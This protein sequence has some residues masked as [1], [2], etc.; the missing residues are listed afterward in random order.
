MAQE[1]VCAVCCQFG[2]AILS[3][4]GHILHERCFRNLPNR[5]KC[6]KCQCVLSDSFKIEKIYINI[7]YSDLND[8][9][10][11]KLWK[12][13]EGLCVHAFEKVSCDSE[14]LRQL[15]E[16]GWDVNDPECGGPNLFY[17]TCEKDDLSKMNLLIEHGIDLEKYGTNGLD[18]ACS[19]CSRNTFERLGNLGIKQ[20]PNLIF[21]LISR[22]YVNALKLAIENG[23]DVNAFNSRGQRPIHAAAQIESL[24]IIE[25]LVK[26]GADFNAVNKEGESIVHSVAKHTD[27]GKLLKYLQEC[28]FNLNAKD[29]YLMTPLMLAVQNRRQRNLEHLLKVVVDNLE[30]VDKYGRTVLHHCALYGSLPALRTL[31]IAGANVNAKDNE[32]R[33]PLHRV[34]ICQGRYKNDKVEYLLDH[35]ADISVRDS[36]GNLP[37][38]YLRKSLCDEL[39]KRFESIV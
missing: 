22:R 6:P 24:E 2:T 29:K 12:S 13:F 17:K 15:E 7:Q 30:D 4:C 33:T 26:N 38:Y 11:R 39:K 32:G 18:F 36:R 16:F 14:T 21:N 23:A 34:S 25:L 19:S 5:N 3:R 31:I 10:I 35:G 37:Y 1:E 27:S 28:G 20:S 9:E 8:R